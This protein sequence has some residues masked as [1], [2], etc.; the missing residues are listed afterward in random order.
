[1]IRGNVL[2][3]SLGYEVQEPARQ[4]ANSSLLSLF[5]SFFWDQLTA[6]PACNRSR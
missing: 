5:K 4:F 6:Y 2:A 3:T 1:M